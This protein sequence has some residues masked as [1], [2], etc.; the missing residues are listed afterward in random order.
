[1]NTLT[2]LLDTLPTL[3]SMLNGVVVATLAIIVIPRYLREK[4][5]GRYIG[6]R[7]RAL[8]GI[9]LGWAIFSGVIIVSRFGTSIEALLRT[10]VTSLIPFFAAL[11]WVKLTDVM[12]WDKLRQIRR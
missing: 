4:H 12:G 6:F 10:L 1:M 5:T 7:E 8:L 3:F 11:V 2:A 9:Y